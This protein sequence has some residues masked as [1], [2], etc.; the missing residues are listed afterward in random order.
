ML[1]CLSLSGFYM[2]KQKK[3]WYYSPCKR[4]KIHNSFTNFVGDTVTH[5]SSTNFVG[6]TV[7]HNSSTNFVGDT[8]I[9]NSSTNFVGDTVTH[10]S[11]TNFVGDTVIHNFLKNIRPKTSN[12]EMETQKCVYR[13]VSSQLRKK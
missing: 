13:K 11:S 1:G 5:N 6:D 8:V 7:I 3:T 4:Y 12:N 10:N 2:N 9:H